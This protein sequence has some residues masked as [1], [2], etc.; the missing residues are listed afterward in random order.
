[1]LAE[2]R[3]KENSV[4]WLNTPSPW[5]RMMGH[6]CRNGMRVVRWLPEKS[7]S[8]A[9]FSTS[10][11]KWRWTP[12]LTATCRPHRIQKWAK[13]VGCLSLSHI[14]EMPGRHHVD[15]EIV[16]DHHRAKNHQSDHEYPERERQ[17]I[18]RVLWPARYMQKKHQ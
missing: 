15:V 10:E 3:L 18:V 17:N 5:R 2:R 8:H 6:W 14:H 16:N 1:M 12:Q 7:P 13:Q 9:D 11:M 4:Q